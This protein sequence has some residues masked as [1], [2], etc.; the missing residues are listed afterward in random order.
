MTPAPKSNPRPEIG[1]VWRHHNGNYYEVMLYANEH[2]TRLDDYPV[3]IVYR[4]QNDRVWSRRLDDWW[5]SMTPVDDGLDDTKG[6]Q[7]D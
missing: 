7:E 5:R 1:S 6:T 2:S 3:M 4:G